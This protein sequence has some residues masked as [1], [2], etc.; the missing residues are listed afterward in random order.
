MWRCIVRVLAVWVV[1]VG[2]A[3]VDSTSVRCADGFVCPTGTVC[4]DAHGGCATLEQ[5]DGCRGA[6]QEDPCSY[7]G[8]DVGACNDGVC[9]PA[10]CG[11]GVV[12]PPER[13]DDGNRIHG[14][15]CSADCSS[16]EQCGNGIIDVPKGE[17]CDD[18]NTVDGD[19]CHADC[20]SPR[21]G[22]GVVDAAYNEA[23]DMGAA[24]SDAPDVPC[25]TNCQPM[26][27]GDGHVDST[28]GEVCDDGN[29][30][31]GDGC[32]GDCTSDETCGNN[33]VDLATGEQ[34]DDGNH[35]DGDGCQDG[36]LAPRCGDG[37]V[38]AVLFEECDD[39]D[40]NNANTSDKCR[41]TCRRPLCG[42]DITDVAAG[43]ICDDQNHNFG[44]GCS[45]DCLSNETCG[46]GYVDFVDG[47]QCDDGDLLA[48][49]GCGACKPEQVSWTSI[50]PGTPNARTSAALAYDAARGRIV[51]FG[52]VDSGTVKNDTWEWNGTA[53]TNVTPPSGNPSIRYGAGMAYDASRRRIVLFGGRDGS[54]LPT[55]YKND[56]WEWDGRVWTQVTPPTGNPS[57]RTT[58]LAYDA[59]RHR[60]VLFGGGKSGASNLVFNDTFEWDGQAWANRTLGSGN[61]PASADSSLAY[62]P[63]R[64]NVV[65]F[66]LP[67]GGATNQTWVWN[68]MTWANVTPGSGNPTPRFAPVLAFDGA[69]GRVLLFG[70]S[71][72]SFFN[73]TWAWNGSAWS[74]VT[75]AAGNPSGRVFHALAY[76]SARR[77]VVLVGGGGT[78][79]PFEWDGAAWAMKTPVT[80]PPSARSGHA[81]AYDAKRARVVLF[82]GYTGAASPPDSWEWTG[83]S[84]ANVTPA[85]TKPAGRSSFASVYDAFNAHTMLFGGTSTWDT[86]E[87]TGSAWIDATPASGNPPGRSGLAAA[88]DTSR[89]RVVMFS[90]G[91]YTASAYLTYLADTWEWTGSG[92][93]DMTPASGGPGPRSG[94]AM[95]FDAAR[96]RAVMFGGSYVPDASTSVHYIDTWEWDADGWHDV[97]PASPSPGPR[98]GHLMVYDARRGRV[99]LIGG[100][101]LIN[102]QILDDIWEWDGSDWTNVTTTS[103]RPPRIADAIAYDEAHGYSVAFG[104][105][106]AGTSYSDTWALRYDGSAERESCRYGLDG[107]GDGAVGCADPDCFG[108]C[109]PLCNP[110]LL[111]AGQ[112]C[113]QAGPRVGDSACNGDET[114]RISTLDC[115]AVIKT[116]GDFLCESPETATSCPGDCTP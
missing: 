49:D 97:T 69:G 85:T 106:N 92:W 34:C 15:G 70:G 2:T 114:A 62:D 90:G 6:A 36:C 89:K 79:E 55:E 53:W 91:Y 86:W 48:R 96:G 60:V 115:G 57:P 111:P 3:C 14:D 39:G 68:G 17:A 100:Q 21:C 28:N 95:A 11:N 66:E 84:W 1:V 73:D 104:G 4:D 110:T 81:L 93:S 105:V 103:S 75:P 43:E 27:C 29:V 9:L 63:V 61:P 59:G 26:R 72:A 16:D 10:G 25:R 20:S 56:T 78:G 112:T 82:S 37:I 12:T 8:V 31:S 41:T 107:D 19:E 47:E 54:G 77:R 40:A 94:H 87:W 109:T 32:S 88:S 67:Q 116:C 108:I 83:S 22:D 58:S 5:L 64:G 44:D 50:A 101:S 51:L 42:D 7:A 13:C 45:A 24:N 80:A 23:C 102:N 38:D 33:H 18:G 74:N 98:I 35:I 76:D 71:G 52:G 46:N 30:T 99:L 65:L 113:P